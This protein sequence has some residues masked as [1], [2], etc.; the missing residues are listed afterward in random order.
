MLFC[1]SLDDVWPTHSS[2]NPLVHDVPVDLG[3]HLIDLSLLGHHDWALAVRRACEHLHSQSAGLMSAASQTQP[4]PSS[5][6][7]SVSSLPYSAPPLTI[8]AGGVSFINPAS[9]SM[10]TFMSFLPMAP[11]GGP[12]HMPE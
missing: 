7:L 6:T 5:T 8:I 2:I 1:S 11:G 4:F 12:F 10:A 3:E 9:F